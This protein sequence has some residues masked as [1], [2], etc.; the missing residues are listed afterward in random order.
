MHRE[1]AGQ[2]A[3]LGLDASRPA[4]SSAD[5]TRLPEI[6]RLSGTLPGQPV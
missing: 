3:I 2:E 5:F 4:R 1:V 6:A